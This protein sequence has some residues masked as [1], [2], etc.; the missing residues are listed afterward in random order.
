MRKVLMLVDSYN[1]NSPLKIFKYEI[2]PFYLG[3]INSS[4]KRP[5]Y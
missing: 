2:L 1:Y 3:N 5:S 4:A